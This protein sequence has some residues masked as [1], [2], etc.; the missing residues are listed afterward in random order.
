MAAGF[1]G[2]QAVMCLTFSQDGRL[3][4]AGTMGG[5]LV[6]WEVSTGRTEW[7]LPAYQYVDA[8]AASPVDDRLAVSGW[9]RG[10]DLTSVSLWN[11]ARG[12]LTQVLI[13]GGTYRALLFGP[14]GKWLACGNWSGSSDCPGTSIVR[15]DSG[16]AIAVLA[17]P[18]SVG[19][20]ALSP[21][22]RLLAIGGGDTSRGDEPPQVAFWEVEGWR[23][24]EGS[25]RN[26][27]LGWAPPAQFVR[28]LAF[29][30][31]GGELAIAGETKDISVWDVH[32]DRQTDLKGHEGWVFGLAF[33][34]NGQLVSGSS[35]RTVR[36]WDVQAG[37][38][39]RTLR[40]HWGDVNDVRVSPD[41]EIAASAS[42]DG[43]VRLWTMRSGRCRAVLRAPGAA[44]RP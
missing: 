37:K 17:T 32:G 19:A 25:A 34:V 33:G 3:L 1:G 27:A 39:L 13:R 18:R 8:V 20:L 35:D 44:P 26:R 43:T 15:A 12:V 41:G 4:V 10:E 40:G 5:V 31:Q 42:N 28:A 29:D 24:V 7:A 9:R 30:A 2:R 6:A 21:D 16:D 14:D 23:R 38:C 36:V 11:G 22:G